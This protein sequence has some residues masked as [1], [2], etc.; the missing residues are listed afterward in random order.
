MLLELAEMM[1]ADRLDNRN[2]LQPQAAGDSWQRLA[3][4]PTVA[5]I[6]TTSPCPSEVA[7]LC[8]A[9]SRWSMSLEI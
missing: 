7:S 9:L 2:F 1:P 8:A 4:V 5:S 6:A 3:N